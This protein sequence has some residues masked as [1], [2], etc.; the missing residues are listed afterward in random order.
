MR[1]FAIF[2]ALASAALSSAQKLKIEQYVL[3]NGM[4]VI[5]NEDHRLPS[6]VINTW[7]RVGSKDERPGR[8]GFAHLFEHLMFT[9]TFR[10]P[11]NGFDKLMEAEGASNNANTWFDRTEYYDFGPA[12]T[13]PLLLYLEADRLEQLGNAMDQKKLDVQRQVVLNERRQTSENQPF[14]NAELMVNEIL[15]PDGH[16]YHF[17][18]IGQPVDLNAATVQ[19]VKDFFATYYVPNNATMIISGDFDPKETKSLI[20]KLFGGLPRKND[21]IH[22][23]A[24]IPVLTSERRVTFVD[25]KAA[26]P[27]VYMFWHSPAAYKPGDAD[28]TIAG[29]ILSDGVSSRL[30]TKLVKELDI[31]TDVQAGQQS[32]G[33]GSLFGVQVTAKPEADL[34]K[35]EAAI[36]EVLSE[37]EAKGPSADEVQR[38]ATKVQVGLANVI[39]DN[40]GRAAKMNAYEYYCGE[41]NWFEKDL[42]RFRAA[43]PE[44]VRTALAA[45]AHKDNRLVMTVLPALPP[46]TGASPLDTKPTLGPS[47]TP[48]FPQPEDFT[49]ASGLKVHYWYR[50]DVPLVSSTFYFPIGSQTETPAKR[51][52]A[53]LLGA[54][55]GRG[56][57]GMTAQQFQDALD[58]LGA[59]FGCDA[60][61]HGAHVS[62][63]SLD[64][65]YAKSLELALR[66]INHPGLREDD[67]KEVKSQTLAAL[68][69]EDK[70]SAV[71]A[72]IELFKQ[73]YGTKSLYGYPGGGTQET[74]AKI[75]LSDLR[76]QYQHSLRAE[77]AE[78]Y[79]SGNITRKDLEQLLVKASLPSGEKAT[80]NPIVANASRPTRGLRVLLVD[81]PD[82]PQTSIRFAFPI[83]TFGGPNRLGIGAIQTA[84]AGTFASRLNLNLRE[85]HGYTYGVFLHVDQDDARGLATIRCSVRSDVS[86]ESV[87]EMFAELAKIGKGDITDGETSKSIAT[88]RDGL[89]QQLATLDSTIGAAIAEREHGRN[90]AAMSQDFANYGKLTTAELNRLVQTLFNQESATLLMVGDAKKVKEQFAKLGL[91]Q[92]EVIGA[93]KR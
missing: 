44:S 41:P 60:D 82:A 16:P 9:G 48:T 61:L 26:Q 32:F 37:L 57:E 7:F 17:D 75:E 1:R 64:T 5:L 51:G 86:G 12:R 14:G 10:A 33:L 89:V 20:N 13:L 47:K 76:T 59:N 30:Y 90:F 58:S 25:A 21:P 65:N 88:L 31:A 63:S 18:T 84:F 8:S 36:D 11:G 22:R 46:A 83:E 38:Q 54:M 49:T 73:L 19:D 71:K 53:S 15:Y 4:K 23:D 77:G 68:E 2:L 43:T 81:D 78:L 87:K 66:A 34:S 74:V 45:I 52:V 69:Q 3:P 62:I 92:I 80:V 79:I 28:L 35:V 85:Q 27:R 56:P 93:I 39:Q 55:I 67:W 91:P 70:N 29:S 42:Q 24:P 40:A 6:V 50:P 72:D